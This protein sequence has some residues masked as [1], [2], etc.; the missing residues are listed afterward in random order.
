MYISQPQTANYQTLS[1]VTA[2]S[3]LDGPAPEGV[4]KGFVLGHKPQPSR[5]SHRAQLFDKAP[6]SQLA[7]HN[8]PG[9]RKGHDNGRLPG[10]PGPAPVY[11]VVAVTDKVHLDPTHSQHI[12]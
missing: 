12:H 10:E 4:R 3:L 11:K 5:P 6:L 7:R 9:A 8:G 2:L 1:L